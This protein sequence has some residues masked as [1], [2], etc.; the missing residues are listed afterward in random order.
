MERY[1]GFRVGGL[2]EQVDFI[3]F[4]S[5]GEMPEWSNGAVSKTVVCLSADRGFESLFLRKDE[6]SPAL[7]GFLFLFE[8][9]KKTCFL[10]EMRI[11]IMKARK[12][13]FHLCWIS[14][15]GSRGSAGRRRRVIPN[16]IRRIWFGFAGNLQRD[17]EDPPVGG[18]E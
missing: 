16:L 12:S 1:I 5:F 3:T 2:T 11:K 18:D 17:H 8:Y 9:P 4:A 7:A 15:R 10:K 14:P 6:I 13:L